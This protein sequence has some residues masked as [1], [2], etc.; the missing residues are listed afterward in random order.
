M[1]SLNLLAMYFWQRRIKPVISGSAVMC[2]S[3][4]SDSGS[5]TAMERTFAYPLGV[6]FSDPAQCAQSGQ[7]AVLAAS[8]DHKTR[9][10]L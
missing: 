10:A 3:Q 9:Q 8:C 4:M 7:E 2:P 5:K 6:E 1:H